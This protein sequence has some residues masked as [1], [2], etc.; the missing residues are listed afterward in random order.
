MIRPCSNCLSF[1]TFLFFFPVFTIHFWVFSFPP[2]NRRDDGSR[3]FHAYS[4]CAPPY[5]HHS[6]LHSASPVP[7]S[8]PIHLP[9]PR[10]LSRSDR[11]PLF[12]HHD[13]SIFDTHPSY[14]IPSS[15]TLRLS[16]PLL[17][18]TLVHHKAALSTNIPPAPA[19]F[20]L[21]NSIA[22]RHR[23]RHIQQ[24]V[25]DATSLPAEEEY[26]THTHRQVLHNLDY[27]T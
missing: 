18:D 10:R 25:C 9:S 13:L 22:H 26:T 8:H 24:L 4:I 21:Q 20:I 16:S 2:L 11:K 12:S 7:V 5:P 6:P 23:H 15:P 3:I 19:P 17:S 1:L 14:R 27:I